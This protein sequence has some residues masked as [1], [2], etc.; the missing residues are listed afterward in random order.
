M[1]P[2]KQQVRD[3]LVGFG[4]CEVVT[5]SLASSEALS[6]L[7][8]E[9]HPVEPKPLSLVNPMTAEQEYLRPNLKANLLPI[10]EANRRHEDGAIRLFEQGRVYL[11]RPHDLPDE[12]EALCGLISAPRLEKSLWGKSEPVDFFEAKGAVESLLR[13]LGVTATFVGS[14]DE[15]LHSDRQAAI[16]IS[17]NRLGVVGELH[18]AVRAKFDLTEPVYLFEIDLSSLLPFTAARSLFQPIPRYPAV[19]RDLALVVD[20]GVTH[21]QVRDIIAGFP[22]VAEL[23]IFDVYSGEQVPPGKKSLAYSIT[24][25]SPTQTLTDEEVNQVQQQILDTLGKKLGAA[26]RAG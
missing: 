2:L 3:I 20:A 21:Q 19:V 4:F 26:L 9:A 15:S 5:Y 7:L 12:R 6:K 23:E 17:G 11:P 25:R 14:T 24:Y 16:I 10:L 8:P 1:P 13:K 18:P 22:L